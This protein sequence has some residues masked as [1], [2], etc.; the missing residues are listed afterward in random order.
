M[1]LKIPYFSIV[2]CCYNSAD[3]IKQTLNSVDLQSFHNYEH[4]LVDGCSDDDT[5]EIIKSTNNCFRTYISEKDD[6]MYHAINKGIARAK[7]KYILILNSDDMLLDSEVLEKIYQSTRHHDFSAFYCHLHKIRLGRMRERKLFQVDFQDLLN[8]RHSTFC[9]HPGLFVRNDIYRQ[10]DF[11]DLEYKYASDLDF[12]L[13]LLRKH[14][15]KYLGFSSTIFRQHS[16][17]ITGRGL[18][19]F[20]RDQIILNHND[21]YMPRQGF[22]YYMLWSWYVL[23]NLLNYR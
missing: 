23:K 15:V 14:T 1:T 10:L 22:K 20:E 13:R 2:T 11:Y 21:G 8:S 12:I 6:G 18:L 16:G 9:P 5:L 3:F 7:G 4:I 19:S 17:S